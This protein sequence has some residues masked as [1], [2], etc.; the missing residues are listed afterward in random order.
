MA[1][2]RAQLH[3]GDVALV[4]A[5]T[6][7]DVWIGDTD[8]V[9]SPNG[10]LDVSNRQTLDDVLAGLVRHGAQRA[11]IDFGRTRFLDLCVVQVLERAQAALGGGLVLVNAHGIVHRVLETAGLLD[12]GSPSDAI[13]AHTTLLLDEGSTPQV[14]ANSPTNCKPRD[15]AVDAP[16]SRR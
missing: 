9:I 4:A 3:S 13:S 11:V 14:D 7:I 15:S 16:I 10:D 6:E 1:L 5:G 8:A 2:D 12:Y